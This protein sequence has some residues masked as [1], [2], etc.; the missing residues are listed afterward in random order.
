MVGGHRVA[1]RPS[2]ADR[3]FAL[4]GSAAFLTW[5]VDWTD[6]HRDSRDRLLHGERSGRRGCLLMMLAGT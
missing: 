1:D 3:S 4:A 2:L 5:R 6:A